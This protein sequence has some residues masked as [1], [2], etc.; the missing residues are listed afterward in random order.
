MNDL[1]RFDD[2]SEKA[3]LAPVEGFGTTPRLVPPRPDAALTALV[4]AMAL[5]VCI[6]VTA[7]AMSFG[8]MQSHAA[9][10]GMAERSVA[11]AAQ[12][13]NPRT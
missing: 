8:R 11:A 9:G 1:I 6:A 4:T 10:P 12:P 2:G 7:T 13:L 3:D 5:A